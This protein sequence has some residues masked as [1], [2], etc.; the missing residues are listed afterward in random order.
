MPYTALYSSTTLLQGL[1]LHTRVYNLHHYI[2]TFVH[3][4]SYFYSLSQELK[5]MQYKLSELD[6]A[7]GT[8]Q[9][10]I[11]TA[12]QPSRQQR[13]LCVALEY[14]SLSLSFAYKALFLGL[15]ARL[16][17]ALEATSLCNRQASCIL[18]QTDP[19]SSYV[20]RTM[21]TVLL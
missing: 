1:D 20:S 6:L 5:A 7:T 2:V 9:A 11:V 21:R 3:E 15:L 14:S 19:A 4:Y 12:L 13:A 16:K 17:L 8:D 10:K 18:K